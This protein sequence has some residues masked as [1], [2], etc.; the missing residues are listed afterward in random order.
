MK[1]QVT[2][3]VVLYGINIRDS[4]TINSLISELLERNHLNVDLI[5][6]NNGPE[7]LS[8]KNDFYSEYKN[9]FNS[10][11]F[12]EYIENKPLSILYND[13]I[14]NY[15]SEKYVFLDYDSI[16]TSS[17]LASIE[18]IDYDLGLPQIKGYQDDV[19]YYPYND[20]NITKNYG[21]LNP[22]NCYSI[23]SGI[24]LNQK[25][26]SFIKDAYTTVFDENYA[27]YG[28]DVSFFKR[29]NKLYKNKKD[30]VVKCDSYILHSLSRVDEKDSF[31]RRKERA[32]DYGI[33]V[34]RYSSLRKSL[35]LCREIITK[36]F[37]MQFKIL[38]YTLYGF[39]LGYHPRT[40]A[41]RK[42]S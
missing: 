39:I 4:N 16:I 22:L 23:G 41:W 30:I 15:H 20:G 31:F 13:V 5:I 33:T 12:E 26:I 24:I 6:C 36:S 34:R 35:G 27:L 17:F 7:Y 19:I 42:N 10:I 11:S 14:N 29:I 18:N 32:L 38:F 40:K 21:L 28:V 3:V 1:N 25:I 9:F 8:D 37:S 2:I